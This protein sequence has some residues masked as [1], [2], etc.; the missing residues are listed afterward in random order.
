MKPIPLRV[1]VL[2]VASSV[3]GV[4]VIAQERSVPRSG[5]EE[6]VKVRKYSETV[7]SPD[8]KRVAWVEELDGEAGASTPHS[9][10]FV[11][12]LA[13]AER[14]PRRIT[15][16]D[17]KVGCVERSI[18]WSPGGRLLA[19]LSDPD[20]QGQLQVYV[21]PVEGGEARRLTTATGLL[22]D[23][24]WLPDGA[25][26]GVLFTRNASRGAGPLQPGEAPNGVIDEKVLEQRLSTIDLHSGELREVSPPD[27]YVYE[28]DW[29]PDSRRCVAIA[30]HG[31]GDNHWYIAQLY[32]LAMATEEMTSILDP[33]MQVAVPR[34]SPDGR[35][36][37]FIGGLMSDE[38][39]AGG[40]IYLVPATGGKA[41]N[42]TLALEGSASWL[43]WQDSSRSILFAEHLD[44][45]SGLAQVD[46]DGGVTQLWKGQER[47]AAMGSGP[48]LSVSASSDQATLAVIRQ[49]FRQ[50]P[51]IWVGAPGKWGAI[52]HANRMARPEW[53]EA[54]SVHW[55]SDDF[56]I[57][58]WI[59][60]PRDLDQARRYP[61]IVVIHGGPSSAFSPAWLGRIRSPRHCPVGATSS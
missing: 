53:G 34:W 1:L 22:A 17:G 59:L 9:E 23:P 41:R 51:E 48:A 52:T 30:A 2:F 49:A 12:D 45:G 32:V 50:P 8:G 47:I 24:R 3:L 18:T 55:K 44:G 7:I 33:K 37:A 35:T 26:L 38:G 36:I 14:K 57:Q 21:A 56:D 27:M 10:I 61:L 29:S 6:Q 13:A 58:G 43:A 40:D 11:A 5:R 60:S 54:T 19:F 42:L 39:V 16:G 15:A 20:Q 46:L 4:T 31:S 28:F 25:R